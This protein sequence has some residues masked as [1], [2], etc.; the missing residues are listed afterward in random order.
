MTE[1]EAKYQSDRDRRWDKR[2]EYLKRVEESH[3]WDGPLVCIESALV[4]S[5]SVCGADA[6]DDYLCPGIKAG[7]QNG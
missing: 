3:K 7:E 5:C 6:S 4:Q 2:Q 1:D